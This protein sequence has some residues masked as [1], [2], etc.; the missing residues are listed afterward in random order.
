MDHEKLPVTV[1]SGFLGAGKTTLLSHILSNAEGKKV[2]VIVNDMSEI[3]I[4]AQILKQNQIS[5]SRTEEKV[6]ELSNGCICCTLRED[7]LEEITDIA[8][9]KKFDY[10]VVESTGISEPLPVA[11]T[12]FFEEEDGKSLSQ[13]A[14]LDTMVTLVDAFNFMQNLEDAD[15]LKE[16]KLEIDEQDERTIADLLTDQVEFADIIVLNKTDLVDEKALQSIKN[17]LKKL[18]PKARVINS[19]YSKVSLD[20]VLDTNSFDFEEAQSHDDWFAYPEI[21]GRVSEV[22]EYRISN[23]VYRRR[24]P[25]HPDRLWKCFNERWQGVVRSKGMYWIA[26]RPDYVGVWSQAGGACN[27]TFS[28]KWLAASPKNEWEFEDEKELQELKEKWDPKFGDRQQE[29]VIIGQGIN[30]ASICKMLDDCLLTDEE[31]ALGSDYWKNYKDPFPEVE[32][33]DVDQSNFQNSVI[34]N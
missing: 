23:F 19:E 18:N 17:L 8:N 27:C 7:L 33:E 25:F 3:N 34:S 9:S 31:L 4:D 5:I 28:A 22:D 32:L 6:V 21:T 16:H 24:K 14:R 1:L 29:M 10:L 11:E 26:S 13:V 20:Q 15:Y 12:F 30:E 2:A